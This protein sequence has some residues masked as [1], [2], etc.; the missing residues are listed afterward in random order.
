M[1][2]VGGV[3]PSGTAVDDGRGRLFRTGTN[4]EIHR[5]SFP[6]TKPKVSDE[7]A[8]HEARLASALGLD[9]AAK[10]L[11]VQVSTTGSTQLGNHP[12]GI[13]GTLSARSKSYWQGSELVKGG[14]NSSEISFTRYYVITMLIR[15][16]A[17]SE[18]SR[19][20]RELPIAPFK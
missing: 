8:R 7:L 15:E 12:L 2:T 13:I 11:E 9:R 1:W 5:T 16:A 20:M 4:A 19:E 10:T 18:R 3:A 14:Q 17:S 6:N